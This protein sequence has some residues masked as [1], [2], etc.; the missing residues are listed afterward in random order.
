MS[1]L[2]NDSA[3]WKR[4]AEEARRVAEQLDDPAAKATMV[5]IAESYERLAEMAALRELT[6]KSGG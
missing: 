4:R 3:H 5:E 1:P 6:G 2:I